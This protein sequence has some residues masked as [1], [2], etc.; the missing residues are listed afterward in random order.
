MEKVAAV[1]EMVATAVAVEGTAKAEEI[2]LKNER[3]AIEGEKATAK[4]EKVMS[5]VE[6]ESKAFNAIKGSDNA[7]SVMLGKYDG[8]G[9]TNYVTKANEF[10]SQYFDL[11]DWSQL[12]S[13]YS[14]SE[15]W[16]IN[17]K[18]LDIQVGSG[19]DIL[20]S[21]NLKEFIIN[22]NSFYSKEVNYLL[23]H[24]FKI[25]KYGDVWRLVR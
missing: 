3:M 10:N 12:S 17:E 23:D 6:A 5:S 11:D 4:S 16:K 19:R 1:V 7:D 9:S 20:F 13:E 2:V 18:F 22:N 25:E 8:G 24:G 15:I 21:H 14:D